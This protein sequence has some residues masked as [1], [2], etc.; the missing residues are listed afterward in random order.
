M[1]RKLLLGFLIGLAPAIAMAQGGVVH[2]PQAGD[3]ELTLSGTGSSKSSMDA[4]T[5]G[6]SGGL[7]WFYTDELEFGVRQGMGYADLPGTSDNRWNGNTR[8]FADYHFV[9][10]ERARPFVGV[11]L[12]AAYGDAVHDSAFGGLEAG[13]KYYVRSKTFIMGAVE[14]QYFFTNLNHIDDGFEDGAFAYTLGIGYHF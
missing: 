5:F 13:L 12:G 11:S 14:Y 6:V 4:A 7:G 3:R 8:G 2:G 1:N 10:G 9:V